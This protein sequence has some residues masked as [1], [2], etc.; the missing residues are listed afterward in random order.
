MAKS[1]VKLGFCERVATRR[2]LPAAAV[3]SNAR[4]CMYWRAVR[5]CIE[6]QWPAEAG[7]AAKFNLL[8]HDEG[9]AGWQAEYTVY[10][11][12]S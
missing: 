8:H 10:P 2:L 4:L 5:P 9:L 6:S 7:F 11:S 3:A 1:G 12:H